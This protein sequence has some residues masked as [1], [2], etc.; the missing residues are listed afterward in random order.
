[1]SLYEKL[2]GEEGIGKVVEVFYEKVLS[3]ETVKH[4]FQETDMEKQKR[5]QTLFISWVLGGPN[6]YTGQGMEKAHEGMNLQ[7]EHFSAIAN[8]LSASLKEFNVSNDDI[9]VVI[10][11]LL[12]MKE[13][14]LHK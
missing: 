10:T 12:T 5:H 13:A 9:D 14:I 6:Q 3:D 1:M 11:K 7:D 4:F 8:H 2:G